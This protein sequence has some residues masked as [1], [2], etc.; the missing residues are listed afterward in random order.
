MSLKKSLKSKIVDHSKV[1]FQKAY[2]DEIDGLLNLE[3]PLR[4]KAVVGYF[5]FYL[6]LSLFGITAGA[7]FIKDEIFLYLV[8]FIFMT[9]FIPVIPM[10]Y[11][12]LNPSKMKVYENIIMY[13]ILGA[14]IVGFIGGSLI[15]AKF[16]AWLSIFKLE[17]VWSFVYLV[18]W[19][20]SV[21]LFQYAIRTYNYVTKQ[22]FTSMQAKQSELELAREIQTRF[23]APYYVKAEEIEIQGEATLA[24]EIGGDY[25]DA[26]QTDKGWILAIGDVSGHGM[27]AGLLMTSMRSA[28]KSEVRHNIEA[29]ELMKQ[30]NFFFL[31]HAQRKL[32]MTF[33]I[34]VLNFEKNE[35]EFVNA[36]HQPTLIHKKND[37]VLHVKPKGV[38]LGIS[39]KA[40]YHKETI[41]LNDIKSICLF[42]DGLTET[43]N[44]NGDELGVEPIQQI[45]T[46]SKD[47]KEFSGSL[48]KLVNEYSS[49]AEKRDDET[50]L[51]CFL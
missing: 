35:L 19:V 22:V 7:H 8:L 37:E 49:N 43:R 9:T 16:D 30:L 31:K 32:F 28:F 25:F 20:A 23:L 46:R 44:K 13:F 42:T 2:L 36:G 39:P 24:S 14:V 45:L 27:A 4:L 48:T 15:G 40:V 34:V 41:S 50:Y 33:S 26:I 47:A 21:T 12:I 3:R 29:V 10:M 17:N 18:V 38:G 11:L 6:I 51:V 5:I 1:F